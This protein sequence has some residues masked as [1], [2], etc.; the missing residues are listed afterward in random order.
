MILQRRDANDSIISARSIAILR[1]HEP[2]VD[3]DHF[4][5]RSRHA[6][7]AVNKARSSAAQI[8]EKWLFGTQRT[9]HEILLLSEPTFSGTW[10]TEEQMQ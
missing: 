4:L 3:F 7:A 5:G 2:P 6:A 9:G 8:L 1:P 10:P